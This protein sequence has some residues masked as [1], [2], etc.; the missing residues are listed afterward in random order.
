[1]DFQKLRTQESQSLDTWEGRSMGIFNKWIANIFRQKLGLA[2]AYCPD[3]SDHIL[4]SGC[5]LSKNDHCL[6]KLNRKPVGILY[7]DI[8][9]YARLTEL[10]EEGTH[11]RLVESMGVIKAH[12]NAS[13]GRIA[14]FAGDAILAEFKDADSAL[15]CAINVQLSAR[16]WNA[17]L[18]RPKHILFR[19][20]VN[21]GEVIAD[22]GDI[23]GNAV[24]LAA[25]LEELASS[26]GICV[27][28]TAKQSLNDKFSQQFVAMNKRYVKNLSRPVRAF[29]IDIDEDG[30][31]DSGH[32]RLVKVSAVAS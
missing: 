7:A 21:F 18:R 30:E 16:Q 31:P 6:V 23:Y 9:G 8:V 11:L 19:I 28:E 3:S 32:S 15:Q 10:D 4:V 26:G 20:G 24:N 25:R 22:R 14:H 2:P 1:M 12:V 17:N 5:G 29:R 13:N 27:S